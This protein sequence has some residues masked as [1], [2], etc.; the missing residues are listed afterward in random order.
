MPTKNS[1]NYSPTQYS[2]QVGGANG[3]L[4]QISPGTTTIP[5]RLTSAGASANPAF[6]VPSAYSFTMA[7]QVF[8]ASGTYTP[9][10]NMKYCIIECI[11]GG[12][13]SGACTGTQVAT[14]IGIAG[15]CGGTYSRGAFSAATIG[16]SQTATVGAGGAAAGGGGTTSI[17]AVITAPGGT[18]TAN[19]STAT[20]TIM[21]VVSGVAPSAGTGASFAFIGMAGKN[22]L[23]A[24]LSTSAVFSVGGRGGSTFFGG[25]APGAGTATNAVKV[26]GTAGV[27]YGGGAS[28]SC[29]ASNTSPNSAGAAGKAGIIVITEFIY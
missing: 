20:N 27:S 18:G 9:T 6:S 21:G 17:G 29:M 24:Y 10:A 16:V 12:G 2:V 14:C 28:G 3:T 22:G 26:A 5:Q 25:G 8:T 15:G 19:N 13:G 1:S 4:S 11:G 23:A 7:R